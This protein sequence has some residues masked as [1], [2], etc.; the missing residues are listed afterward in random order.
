MPLVSLSNCVQSA[1][2]GHS[3]D[4]PGYAIEWRA[5]GSLLIF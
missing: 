2:V 5:Y 4:F 1:V 3:Q